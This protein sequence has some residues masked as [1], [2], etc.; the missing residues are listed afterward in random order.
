[1][2][3][4][5]AAVPD[6]SIVVPTVGRPNL[7]GL[8]RAL[9]GSAAAAGCPAEILLVDDRP[10][11]DQSGGGLPPVP[12]QLAAAV[13]VVAG[14][15]A[16]PAAARNTGW[17]AA[18]GEWIAFLDDD[19]VPAPDWL[20]RLARDLRVRGDVGGVQG[21]VRVPLPAHRRPTD[22]ERHTRGL[23]GARWITADM[24]Y[25][26]VALAQVGGFDERFTRAY[27]EDSELAYR[28]AAA[29]WRLVA[30]RRTVAHPVRPEGAWVS[31]WSQRGNADDALLRRI[32][33]PGWR[34]RL[35][36][37]RGRRPAHV[38][39]TVTLAATVAGGLAVLWGPRARR[40]AGP[41]AAVAGSCWLAATGQFA[42]ARIRAGPL[43]LRECGL[44]VLTSAAIPP[45]ATLQWLRGWWAAHGAA[46]WAG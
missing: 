12:P 19:V 25:R 35:G 24:A 46:P 18:R 32:Y 27:R 22:W 23:A 13:R 21:T 28:V 2:T 1:M 34:H 42:W 17:R 7:G 14:R 9:A 6:V 37:P 3:P 5:P 4:P 31:L 11:S 20:A 41:A 40:I 43:H 16:G 26:R 38:C 33:G 36:L 44:M 39:T 30:G 8:L 45:L 15:G 10:A 29:G